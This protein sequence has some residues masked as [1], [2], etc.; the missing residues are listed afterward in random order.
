MTT[1]ET[2]IPH[3]PSF[4]RAFSYLPDFWPPPKQAVTS[5]AIVHWTRDPAL[6]TFTGFSSPTFSPRHAKEEAAEKGYA[7]PA[8][9]A[10]DNARCLLH[11]LAQLRT[12]AP[13]VYP[14]E[15]GGVGIAMGVKGRAVLVVC[16]ERGGAACFASVDHENRR[17]KYDR[18]AVLPDAFV[19][20][21]LSFLA[22]P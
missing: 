2:L 21:Q 3:T 9:L 14:T 5:Q 7:P 6:A 17:A 12:P 8:R 19:R 18:A 1:I 4:S 10:I 11:R 13:A 20:E 15:D 22:S 16:D